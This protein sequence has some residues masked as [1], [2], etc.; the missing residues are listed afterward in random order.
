MTCYL[1][2]NQLCVKLVMDLV[3]IMNCYLF[4]WFTICQFF[5]FLNDVVNIGHFCLHFLKILKSL[6]TLSR[7]RGGGCRSHPHYN[8]R[9]CL[10]KRK[11]KIGYLR[12]LDKVLSLLPQPYLYPRNDDIYGI[13][14]CVKKII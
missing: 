6:L 11:K 12:W 13:Q 8:C 10:E 3:Y 2:T 1:H 4:V 7:H 5:L 9:K 14:W